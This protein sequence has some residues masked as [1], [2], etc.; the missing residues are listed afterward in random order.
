MVFGLAELCGCSRANDCVSARVA[1]AEKR[2]GDARQT[3]LDAGSG[4]T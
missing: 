3:M 2:F 1:R 4:Q